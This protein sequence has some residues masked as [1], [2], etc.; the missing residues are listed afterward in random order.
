[1]SERNTQD[2]GEVRSNE[3]D[4]DVRTNPRE[5][6]KWISALV[7]LIGAWLVVQAYL[8]D[9]IAGNFWSDIIVGVA[10]V[11]LG[12][13]NYYRRSDARNGSVAVGGFVALLGLWV[14]ATPFL[15][16]STE[17]TAAVQSDIEFWNDIAVGT[18]VFL[19]GTYSAYAAR[20]RDAARTAART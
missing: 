8:L 3:Y 10:L 5:T 19:L 17:G 9:P 7:A 18:G 15:L 1:M 12:G 14:I 11:A 16:G 4:D 6:G 20:N 13:Y 2:Q